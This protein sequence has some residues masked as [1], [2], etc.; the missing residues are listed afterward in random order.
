MAAN[1]A[2]NPSS[3]IVTGVNVVAGNGLVA[4]REF[5]KGECIL[6]ENALLI[7]NTKKSY[8][9]WSAPEAEAFFDDERDGTTNRLEEAYNDLS[10]AGRATYKTLYRQPN[11]EANTQ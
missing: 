2:A 6:E 5:K 3:T 10:Q 11:P 1:A 9:Q 7:C 4:Q 8:L